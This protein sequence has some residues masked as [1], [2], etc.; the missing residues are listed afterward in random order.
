M[1]DD[2]NHV[3]LLK[4]GYFFIGFGDS[5]GYPTENGLFDSN[6]RTLKVSIIFI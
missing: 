1:S 3:S 4:F 6:L 5:D 2:Y